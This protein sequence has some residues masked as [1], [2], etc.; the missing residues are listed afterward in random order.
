MWLCS[1]VALSKHWVLGA[2][3]GL[4]LVDVVRFISS[5]V[6]SHAGPSRQARRTPSGRIQLPA[7]RTGAGVRGSEFDA[8]APFELV[9]FLDESSARSLQPT[10]DE[11]LRCLRPSLVRRADVRLVPITG[12]LP[13]ICPMP[14]YDAACTHGT[15]WRDSAS[16]YRAFAVPVRTLAHA[17]DVPT[18][19][20]GAVQRLLRAAKL[21]YSVGTCYTIGSSAT[22]CATRTCCSLRMSAMWS[23]RSASCRSCAI[24]R[25]RSK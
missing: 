3:V 7:S 14:H 5:A 6:V 23:S 1:R 4:Q 9:M 15:R 12:A 17:C 11:L 25:L 8:H 19:T 16:G 24:G 18:R 10:L 21:R 22:L 20:I 2:A 13:P